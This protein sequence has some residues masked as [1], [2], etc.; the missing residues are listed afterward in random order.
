MWEAREEV[1]KWPVGEDMALE[2]SKLVIA[3]EATLSLNPDPSRQ[4]AIPKPPLPSENVWSQCQPQ[5]STKGP[6]LVWLF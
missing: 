5:R 4:F 1:A 2:T 6:V 3:P